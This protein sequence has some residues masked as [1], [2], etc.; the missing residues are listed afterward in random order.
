MDKEVKRV[1]VAM[2]DKN[3]GRII[4]GNKTTTIRTNKEFGKIG[5]EIG[6][7]GITNFGGIDYLVKCRGYMSV[8]EA[9][10]KDKVWE[11]EGFDDSGPTFDHVRKWLNGFGKLYVYDIKLP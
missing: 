6:E 10:G 9:G 4:K 3:I 7:E 11:S 2:M 1:E 5:L 8:D